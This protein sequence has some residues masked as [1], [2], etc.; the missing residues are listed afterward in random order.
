[1]TEQ[2]HRSVEEIAR[3]IL[4]LPTLER[5]GSD[6]LDFPDVSVWMI[7]EALEAAYRLGR[8]EADREREALGR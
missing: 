2:T 7:R 4:H 5:R 1:M 6:G 8:D 3:R